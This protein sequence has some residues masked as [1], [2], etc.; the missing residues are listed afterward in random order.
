M[1]SQSKEW[2]AT[3]AIL[4][5]AFCILAVWIGID[6]VR[7]RPDPTFFPAGAVGVAW[8][9]LSTLVLAWLLARGSSPRIAFSRA[10]VL[11]LVIVPP[12]VAATYGIEW[13]LWGTW[14]AAVA[15]VVIAAFFIVSLD[16]AA[17]ALTGRPQQAAVMLVIVAALGLRWASDYLEVDTTFWVASDVRERERD[18][19]WSSAE[20]LLFSQPAKMDAALDAVRPGDAATTDV[21]FVGFAGYGEQHL[22][23]EEIKLAASVVAERYGTRERHLLLINDRRDLE[24]TPLA[25]ATT[26]R[27]ALKRIAAKM[28]VDQDILFLALSSH[29]TENWALRVVNGGLPLSNLG[30]TDL[31]GILEESGIKWRIIAISA[32]YGGGFIEALR[33]EN[34]IVLTAAA[35]DR[36]SFGCADDRDLTYFGEAFY[37]DALPKAGSLH[38]VFAEAKASVAERE[39]R[40][41]FQASDPRAHF[42]EALDRK[43]KA[44]EGV[45]Y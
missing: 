38:D 25:T 14:W 18:A 6:W 40:E 15:A 12:V 44:I 43:L 9:T 24:N 17:Y 36:K 37:R 8:H 39:A 23:A 26:L 21:F 30:A 34:S 29:G 35:P 20:P 27:Y 16:R 19:T 31:A 32:C 1:D 41:G 11:M 33:N 4:C 3:L 22:F 7:N 10:L 42:G 13:F 28:D 5:L 45:R 2:S